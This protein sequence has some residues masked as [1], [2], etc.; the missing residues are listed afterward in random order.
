MDITTAASAFSSSSS[1][2]ESLLVLRALIDRGWR[3]RDADRIRELITAQLSMS[4][5]R[6]T[7]DSIESELLNMDLRSIGGKCLPEPSLLFKTS[8]LQGP[9]VLQVRFL[10]FVA[11]LNVKLP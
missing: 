3:F 9:L 11:V 10:P 2:S 7:V 4:A 5:S 8:H 1:S 6:C